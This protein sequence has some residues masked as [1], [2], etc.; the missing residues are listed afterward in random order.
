MNI[1][2]DGVKI[3]ATD[4][5]LDNLS[6]TLESIE[7]GCLALKRRLTDELLVQA[8]ARAQY[9]DRLIRLCHTGK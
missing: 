3:E 5:D 8:E 1:R 6:D 2:F 9:L 4:A 7:E